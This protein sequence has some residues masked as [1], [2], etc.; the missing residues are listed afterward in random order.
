MIDKIKEI[1]DKYPWLLMVVPIVIVAVIGFIFFS[2]KNNASIPNKSVLNESSGQNSGSGPTSQSSQASNSSTTQNSGFSI[3]SFLLRLFGNNTASSTENT[4]SSASSSSES[5]QLRNNS[6]PQTTTANGSGT[7]ITS[8]SGSETQNTSNGS[9]S[10]QSSGNAISPTPIPIIFKTPGGGTEVYVPPP[11][12][13]VATTWARYINADDRYSI[14]YPTNWQIVKTEYN[15]HEGVSLYLPG[16]NTSD[17]NA[18]YIGFGF[19][20]YYLLPTGGSQQ[21]TYS[22][23]V[24]IS[25]I[26][27]TMYTQGELGSGA[28]ALVVQTAQGYFGMGSNSS[29]PDFIYI[30]Y[31]MLQ[32]LNFGPQ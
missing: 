14:D 31:H 9:Q 15:G 2:G 29:G 16:T 27:G 7:S 6:S 28:M 18:Q 20:S 13:P 19:A 11:T 30:Y 21:N 17:Q 1:S 5:T 8:L 4:T 26:N 24:T 32:S 25:G 3:F 22:Y 23:P 10:S 12:P